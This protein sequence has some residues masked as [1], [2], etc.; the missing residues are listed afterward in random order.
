MYSNLILLG[1]TG[2]IGTQSLDVARKHNINV[3]ALSAHKNVKLLEEQILE[4]KPEYICITD[5]ECANNFENRAKELGV[6]LFKGSEGA[7]KLAQL[8]GYNNIVVLNA[9][10]GIA[11]LKATLAAIESGK[12]VALANKESLVTGGKLVMDAVK[13]HNVK[14]LPVDSEH[15]AIFQ[16]LQDKNSAPSLK[17]ILLTASGGPFFGY[18]T[19]QLQTVTKA[20]ALKH[21]NWS[22][23][24]KITIDSATLMNKGLELIEAVWLFDVKP[25]DVQIVV[26]RQSIIHSMVQYADNSVIAQLGSPDMR[27]PIQYSLTYPERMECNATEVDFFTVKDFTFAPADVDT[28]LC[29]KAAKTAIAKGG[30]Y[31]CAVNGANERAVELFLQDKI[32]FLDIGKAVY[33]VISHLDCKEDYTL[34]DVITTDRLAREYVDSLFGIK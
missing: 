32:S 22:M 19:E 9:I 33:G 14:L 1:S 8:D 28:F 5:N 23:G 7:Q 12:D 15:S 21:P 17:K 13:K 11:G 26:H 29:L 10:V 18:S 16:C 30:L 31:P 3:V 6:V 2:S 20:Q 27:I 24:S 34:E 4:F 25:E